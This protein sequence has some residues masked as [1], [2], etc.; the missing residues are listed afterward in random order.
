MIMGNQRSTA[1]RI[2]AHLPG[3]HKDSASPLGT[4]EIEISPA[5]AYSGGISLKA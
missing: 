5:S 2:Q 4:L 1:E 3:A